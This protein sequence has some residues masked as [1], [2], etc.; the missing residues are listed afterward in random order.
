VIP[1]GLELSICHLTLFVHEVALL[2]GF[3]ARAY[4]KS[5]APS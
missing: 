2:F 1:T 3:V 4:Q 5:G